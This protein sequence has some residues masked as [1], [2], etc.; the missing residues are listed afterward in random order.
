MKV[1]AATLK[2]T[3]GDKKLKFPKKKWNHS[4]NADPEEVKHLCG[5]WDM[6]PLVAGILL[7]RGFKTQEDIKSFLR[8]SLNNLRDP[9]QL[10]HMQQAVELI[11]D[12][13]VNN[14]HIIILGDYDVDGITATTL[15]LEFLNACGAEKADY[16][17]PNRLKHGY[18]LTE[19]S[20]DILLERN[21]DLVIT[22][23]NG[24]TAAGEIQR[25]NDAGIK[26]IVTDHHLAETDLLPPGIVINPN[27]PECKYPFKKISGCGVALKLVMALRK[28]L[29]TLGW[30]TSARPE[31]NLRNSLDLAALGTVADVVPL[32]DEN[33]IITYH[34]LQVMN[35]KP[36][37]AIQV[38]KN[39]KKVETITS[40]T[41][42]FQFGP[43]MN[44]AGRL[45]DADLA[46]RFLLSNDRQEAEKMAQILD[47]TNVERREKESEMIQTALKLADE[48]KDNPALILVSPEFHEG[49]NGIVATR[50]VESFYK[51][52]LIL[53]RN[54]GKLKGSG[55]SIP[56]LNLKDVLSDCSDL[57][58]RFGGHAAA[59]G[60]SLI[61]ENLEAFRDRFIALCDDRLP[62]SL[63][64]K[65]QLDGA[66]D[67]SELTEQFMEQLN[68]LQPF[69]EGNPDPLFSVNSPES[70][71]TSLKQKHVKWKLNGNVE[72]IG[73]N[74]SE[75][76]TEDLPS[77]L[78]VNLGFNEFR[79]QRSI[80]L[81]IQDSQG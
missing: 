39:L 45:K 18:G 7:H 44:A 52:V 23:D 80:Q 40:S 74:R 63:V 65:L 33:R 29:R 2:T 19:T 32:L 51:P 60:C 5:E 73:W 35:D 58:E 27:H 77:E 69:G 17:I 46:V 55:R 56:E 61:P 6:H 30:W 25:L 1:Q 53:S 34:G 57:L 3:S 71:F 72:I 37:L 31:P 62:A 26:T 78:A 70:P 13:I 14:R 75:P 16:F 76:F 22:V 20:T 15:V 24:I 79:G 54:E 59:A 81:I 36:R 21:A 9:F 12:V 67:Y 11:Q 4:S 68:R 28:S 38:L 42:A 43:L 8:P 48:Q 10:R 47:A 49:V 41:L 66:L 50:L 64:P